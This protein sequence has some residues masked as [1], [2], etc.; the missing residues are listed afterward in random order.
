MPN[1]LL[2]ECFSGIAGDMH[3][4]AML[5]I[6]LPQDHLFSELEKLN[7]VGEFDIR[8]EQAKKQGIS[9]TRVNV[10]LTNTS[11]HSRHLSE[12]IEII[13]SS[14]L[15]SS[16]SSRAIDMF[17]RL[18]AAEAKVHDIPIESVHFHEVG[19]IDAIVDICSAAI[20]LEWLDVSEVYCAEVELGSG[21]VKCAH[22]LLP[23]PA[24]ATGLLLQN[25]P[26]TRGNVEGEATTPTGATILSHAVNKWEHPQQFSVNQSAY[27]IGHA[28]FKRPNVVRLSLGQIHTALEQEKNVCLECNID[29]MSSEAYEPLMNRLFELGAKDVFFTPITMKK[30]RPGVKLTTLSS[31]ETADQLSRC[32]LENTTSIGLRSYP[33]DKTMLPRKIR[34]METNH[35]PITVKIVSLPDGSKRWKIEHDDVVAIA[36]KTNQDYLTTRRELDSWVA[37]RFKTLEND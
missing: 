9:G 15:A 20:A 4:A 3:L 2:Y 5:D 26:T 6:G 31:Q 16:T 18:G 35:G 24:P 1:A 30:S 32:I 8:V 10:E 12:I 36:E 13:G 7:L 27:G 29:D 14:N 33:V 22:G 34:E 28:D 11:P 25:C 19:A 21:L 37:E 17:E 23:V